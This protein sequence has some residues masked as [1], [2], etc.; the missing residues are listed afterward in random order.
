MVNKQ[1]KPHGFKTSD[2]SQ[3][4]TAC[5]KSIKAMSKTCNLQYSICIF[6]CEVLQRGDVI[7]FSGMNVKTFISA[8]QLGTCL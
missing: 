5:L 2:Y 4:A 7:Q 6:F 1:P 8:G 3:P